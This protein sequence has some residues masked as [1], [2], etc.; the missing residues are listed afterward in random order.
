MCA[1]CLQPVMF[2]ATEATGKL[3][4][5]DTQQNG[6]GNVVLIRDLLG[7][8]KVHV[9]TK[10]EIERGAHPDLPRYMPHFATCLAGASRRAAGNVSRETST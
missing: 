6:A 9:L 3:M 8:Q 4:P 7:E 2:V 5:L 10:D 1:A